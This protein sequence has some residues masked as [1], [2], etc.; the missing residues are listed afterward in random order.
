MADRDGSGRSRNQQP[1]VEDTLRTLLACASERRRTDSAI[2]HDDLLRYL[3]QHRPI[4][5]R[6]L[7]DFVSSNPQP[8]P[9]TALSTPTP[10]KRSEVEGTPPTSSGRPCESDGSFLLISTEAFEI[11][12]RAYVFI[13]H[14]DNKVR[15]AR[16][17]HRMLDQA[18]ILARTIGMGPFAG[19]DDSKH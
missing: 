11:S 1:S 6:A 16:S 5:S 13:D 4:V 3:S 2:H 7:T 12:Q 14:L 19:N 10:T 18:N 9:Q 8:I 17:E 15:V